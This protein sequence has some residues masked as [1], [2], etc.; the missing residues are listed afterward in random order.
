MKNYIDSYAFATENIL[1]QNP[2]TKD[3]LKL[4]PISTPQFLTSTIKMTDEILKTT[5]KIQTQESLKS[6]ILQSSKGSD[7]LSNK[8]TIVF[9]LIITLTTLLF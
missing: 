3:N 1:K 5:I 9:I 2:T 4:I 7:K 8:V 6:N